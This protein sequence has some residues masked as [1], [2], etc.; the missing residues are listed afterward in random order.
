[1]ANFRDPVQKYGRTDEWRAYL[2]IPRWVSNGQPYVHKTVIH[3]QNF[4]NPVNGAN[5]Q[6]TERAWR[7]AR[8]K[9]IKSANNVHPIS[10]PGYSAE[11]WCRSVHG[12]TPFNDS[13]AAVAKQYPMH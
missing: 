7:C 10:L 2:N 4:V 11:L 1:M 3:R 13:V 12:T 8:L 9:I 5:T 6:M